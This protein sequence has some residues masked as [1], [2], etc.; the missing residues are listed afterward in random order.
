M[1]SGHEPVRQPQ[2]PGEVPEGLAQF[3]RDQD[4]RHVGS[5][6]QRGGAFAQTREAPELGASG[7]PHGIPMGT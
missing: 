4:T 1:P 7:Q 3:P 2:A 6:A 5:A